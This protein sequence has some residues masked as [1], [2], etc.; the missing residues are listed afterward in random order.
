ME[1]P[2]VVAAQLQGADREDGWGSISRSGIGVALPWGGLI[3]LRVPDY[4]IREVLHH[5]DNSIVLRANHMTSKQRV[6]IKLLN[7]GRA[8]SKTV[9]YFRHEFEYMIDNG[10][11]SIVQDKLPGAA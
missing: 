10:G 11:R 1:I 5:T 9:S 6:I 4:E 7:S 8:D 2:R 3:M